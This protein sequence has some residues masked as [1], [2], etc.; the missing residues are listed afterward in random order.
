MAEQNQDQQK[1]PDLAGLIASL[2]AIDAWRAGA[3]SHAIA[4][5]RQALTLLP[6]GQQLAPLQLWRGVCLF[7]TG[8]GYLSDGAFAEA[9]A[10]F[11]EAHTCSLASGDEHF[12]QGLLILGG[13]C[14]YLLGEIY[15]AREY[16]QRALLAGRQ[17][18]DREIVARALLGLAAIAFDWNQ[19]ALA[20]QQAGEALQLAPEAQQDVRAEAALQ[21]AKLAHAR[22]QSATARQQIDELLA[23]LQMESSPATEQRLADVLLFSAHLA[24]EAGEPAKAGRTVEMLSPARSL[25]ARIFQ[26]RLLISQGGSQE[27]I[28][29]L[30]HL[31]PEAA[32]WPLSL[33]IQLL[34][35]LAHA[36]RGESSQ[37]RQ[38]LWQALTLARGMELIRP[39]LAEK[40]PVA[41]LLR[42]LL[43]ALGDSALR[44]YAQTLLRAFTLPLCAEASA[45]NA[46]ANQLAEPLSAQEERVLRLL[47]AGHSNREIAQT[48]VISLNTVKDHA[49]HLYR[50]LGISNRQQ[51]SEAARRLKLI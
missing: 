40:E 10:A 36:A 13:A 24:L 33:E 9:L 18:E 41:R 7:I 29:R 26:A 22:G 15:Q 45:D 30:E 14:S 42:Q 47:A 48:L 1:E 50:K 43:P 5:A 16:Y 2:R 25:A 28:T 31:L 35:S 12:I 21:L 17:H 27:A 11:R 32:Q 46:S 51:A 4:C 3:V 20:E 38:W 39:F 34:L 19:L 44:S 6:S 23:H 49:K 37:A 8:I